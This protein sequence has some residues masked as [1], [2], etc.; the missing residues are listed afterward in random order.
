MR[1]GEA[2]RGAESGV[3]EMR[4]ALEIAGI[5]AC[6]PPEEAPFERGQHGGI[7][8]IGRDEFGLVKMRVGADAAGEFLD[9]EG[10]AGNEVVCSV[11]C[12]LHPPSKGDDPAR[13]G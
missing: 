11:P 6:N 12:C 9:R 10:L 2:G 8:T 13:H 5:E 4:I 1:A 3:V 7:E